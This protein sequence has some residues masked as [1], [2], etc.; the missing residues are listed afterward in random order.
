MQ[1]DRAV[2]IQ[3]PTEPE[4]DQEGKAIQI[5]PEV[6]FFTALAPLS[7]PSDR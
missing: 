4:L 1:N 6:S 2:D 3:R 7:A 5:K